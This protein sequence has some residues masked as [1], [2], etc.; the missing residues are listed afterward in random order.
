MS[1]FRIRSGN[2]DI[3]DNIANEEDERTEI[4]NDDESIPEPTK[5]SRP[6]EANWF[7][8][9]V[10]HSDHKVYRKMYQI[11]DEVLL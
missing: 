7:T 9:S 4:D 3:E 5:T 11:L 6:Y 10:T 1:S 8:S 2:D